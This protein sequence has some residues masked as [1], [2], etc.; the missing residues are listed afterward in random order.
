MPNDANNT[1]QVEYLFS[2]LLVVGHAT[3]FRT[4][5]YDTY[6]INN[7]VQMTLSSVELLNFF[8]A[9]YGRWRHPPSQPGFLP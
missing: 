7:I 5:R 6:H 2:L 8:S 3:M 1:W 9:R 4:M